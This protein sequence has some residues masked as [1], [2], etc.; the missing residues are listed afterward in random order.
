MQ[1]QR[2]VIMGGTSGIG[3]ATARAALAAGADVIVTG[4]DAAKLEA[5]RSRLGTAAVAKQVDAT[6]SGAAEAFFRALGPYEHLVLALSG[7]KG[8]GAFKELDLDDL[9]GGFEGKFWA[10]LQV[11]KAGHGSLRTG[12]SVTFITAVSARMARHG[13]AGLAAING[14]L[15]AMV[16]TLALELAPTRV[17]AV[18]PGVV[19][20]PWWD[21]LPADQRAAVF[22]EVAGSTPVGRIGRA[23]DVADAVVFLMRNGF[24]TGNVLVCDGG[25]RL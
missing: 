24:V 17:N 7:G 12:G 22:A 2:V 6:S 3:L 5:A 11:L 8:R 20:T 14:A 15:E 21:R 10:H 18:S 25:L 19:E 4:R 9:R 1:G 16:P 23:E 13:T